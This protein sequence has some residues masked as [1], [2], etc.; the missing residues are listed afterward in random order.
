VVVAALSGLVAAR[1]ANQLSS[2]LRA[3]IR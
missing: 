3:M 1:A 2:S